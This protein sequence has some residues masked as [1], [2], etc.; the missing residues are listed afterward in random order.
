MGR[1]Q[2]PAPSLRDTGLIDPGDCSGSAFFVPGD[3]VDQIVEIRGVAA[4][5]RI[6]QHHTSVGER[7]HAHLEQPLIAG[8]RKMN[9]PAGVADY[10]GSTSRALR[11]DDE[12]TQEDVLIGGPLRQIRN[13]ILEALRG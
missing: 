2:R 8:F 5:A 12:A 7:G 13:I 1:L 3:S 10:V 11:D 6:G 9:Q 4:L